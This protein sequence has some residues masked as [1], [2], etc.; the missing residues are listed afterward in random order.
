MGADDS[1]RDA[2]T[3]IRRLTKTHTAT[4]LFGLVARDART[5]VVLRRGPSKHVRMLLWDLATDEITPGQWLAGRVYDPRCGVS[6]DGQLVVY[7][8]GKFGTKLRTFTAVSRPPYFTALALWPEGSTWGG[9]GFFE[10]NRKLILE[11]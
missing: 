5:A 7:F 4:R 8:A 9:G 2:P 6:P 10:E 3:L 1:G 11:L